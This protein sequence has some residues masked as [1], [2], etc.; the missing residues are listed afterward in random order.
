MMS[1]ELSMSISKENGLETQK[2]KRIA[3]NGFHLME[4]LIG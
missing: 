3:R 2:N 4:M 1:V